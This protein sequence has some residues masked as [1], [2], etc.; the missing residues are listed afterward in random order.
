MTGLLFVLIVLALFGA[1]GFSELTGTL[2]VPVMKGFVVGLL[3][4]G[5]LAL[6]GGLDPDA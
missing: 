4:S 1:F 2:F 3:V 6:A 5:I